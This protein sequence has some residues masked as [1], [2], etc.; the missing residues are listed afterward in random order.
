M[1]APF[2][3][4]SLWS[5]MSTPLESC[6]LC[7]NTVRNAR[8]VIYAYLTADALAALK[9]QIEDRTPDVVRIRMYIPQ[10]TQT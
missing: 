4:D 5:K 3:I 7:H 9:G 8:A 1:I 6:F 10:N 2:L